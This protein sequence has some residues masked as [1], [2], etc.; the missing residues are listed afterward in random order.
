MIRKLYHFKARF[1]SELPKSKKDSKKSKKKHKGTSINDSRGNSDYDGDQDSE[2]YTSNQAAHLREQ[3]DREHKLGVKEIKDEI[4]QVVG[5][6]N[7]ASFNY[8]T[9][10]I[11]KALIC[12]LIFR[13]R[14]GLR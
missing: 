8:K 13:D 5:K 7:K 11:L 6:A 14:K 1:P 2:N 12:C 10:S 4:K 3:L 9:L